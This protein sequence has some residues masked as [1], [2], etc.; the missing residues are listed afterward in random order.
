MGREGAERILGWLR[1]I[2]DL[3]WPPE[4]ED[5]PREV[6]ETEQQLDALDD[7]PQQR[8]AWGEPGAA[9]EM[10][11]AVKRQYAHAPRVIAVLRRLAAA[12]T[13]P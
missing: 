8:L 13:Q 2:V 12:E 3:V 1:E 6:L 10:L 9:A 5:N 11:E 7:G 4:E